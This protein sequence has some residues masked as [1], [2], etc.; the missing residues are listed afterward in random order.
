MLCAEFFFSPGLGLRY[1]TRD[2]KGPPTRLRSG[3]IQDRR[4]MRLI[5][6]QLTASGWAPPASVTRRARFSRPCKKS[7]G[8]RLEGRRPPPSSSSG[9][10]GASRLTMA[11]SLASWAPRAILFSADAL[12][13]PREDRFSFLSLF[14]IPES[15]SSDIS[16]CGRLRGTAVGPLATACRLRPAAANDFQGAVCQIR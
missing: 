1:M 12:M 8:R 4:S 11:L 3:L 16:R 10:S 13:N 6:V 2:S 14:G 9:A 5:I 7:P 15:D